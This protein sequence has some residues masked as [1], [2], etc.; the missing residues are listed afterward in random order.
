MKHFVEPKANLAYVVL[1][2]GTLEMFTLTIA[3]YLESIAPYGYEYTQALTS[4]ILGVIII[5]AAL[6]G[7]VVGDIGRG[8]FAFWLS[9]IFGF[10]TSMLTLSAVSTSIG[11]MDELLSRSTS[12][13]ALEPRVLFQSTSAFVFLCLMLLLVG[14]F[15]MVLVMVGSLYREWKFYREDLR[16]NRNLI[17]AGLLMDGVAVLI[18]IA[19]PVGNHFSLSLGVWTLPI[20]VSLIGLGVF[21]TVVAFTGHW[22]TTAAYSGLLTIGSLVVAVCVGASLTFANRVASVGYDPCGPYS[23]AWTCQQ[24]RDFSMVSLVLLA[25]VITPIT[26][27]FATSFFSRKPATSIL[28]K[29]NS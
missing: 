23:L 7:Y 18:P 20:M 11:S 19:P 15:G 29:G 6:I 8:L 22:I 10:L 1:I 14:V 27:F 9:Q 28:A 5:I 2:I 24:Y 4:I 16:M 25:S 3:A 13:E 21:S 12:I 17:M 26:V